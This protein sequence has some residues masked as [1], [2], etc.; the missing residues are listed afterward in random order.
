MK[1]I[2]CGILVKQAKKVLCSEC[3]SDKHS[4]LKS[5]KE[6][7]LL[8]CTA[9]K[10]YKYKKQWKPESRKAIENTVLHHCTFEHEPEKTTIKLDLKQTDSKRKQGTATVN[11]ETLIEGH[12]VKEEFNF[13]VKVTYTVCDSCA[14]TNT[15]YFEGILQLR[16][17]NK[18]TLERAFK[19]VKNE[20]TKRNK[21]GVFVNKIDE[22]KNGFDLYYTRQRYIPIIAQELQEKFGATFAT[23]AQLFTRKK[24]KDLYRVN[25]IVRLPGYGLGSICKY[26]GRIVQIEKIGRITKGRDLMTNKLVVLNPKEVEVL[27]VMLHSVEVTKHYPQLEVL[28][29]ETFQSVSVANCK[30]SSQEQMHVVVVSEKVW[31]VNKV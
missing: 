10:A 1:C 7:T 21:N 13:P 8:I 31:E 3:F 12:I 20:T 22:H 27:D 9:C 26:D 30:K 29:P 25:A 5:Y 4:C 11:T 24:G 18:E 23:S 14:V 17:E 2:Q 19:Y 16:G 28:H 15:Q 6:H